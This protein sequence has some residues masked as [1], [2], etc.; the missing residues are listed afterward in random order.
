MPIKS[1]TTTPA[2]GSLVQLCAVCG[3]EHTISFNRGGQ[4]TKKGPFSLAV[5]DTLEVKVD[6]AAPATVTFSAGSFPDFSAVTS[7]QLAAKLAASLTGIT[8]SDDSGGVLIES[9]STGPNSR[10]E[11]TGGS[12][13]AA[14]GFPID[15]RLDPCPTR[16]VLGVSL[17]S[18]SGQ[19]KDKNLLALR[20]CSDCGSNECLV[21]TLDVAPPELDGT[22]FN[23]HRKSVNALAEHFKGQGWSHPDVAADHAAEAGPPPNID[24]R[25]PAQ[26]VTPPPPKR[27]TPRDGHNTGGP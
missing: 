17:G 9:V 2:P 26:P 19:M 6:T 16:P 12:A 11:L 1:M 21:R 8:A 5:G 23:E 13:R 14:L 24:S 18:G 3:A 27:T 7:A 4:K 22:F 25:F 10:I 15:G 20:R